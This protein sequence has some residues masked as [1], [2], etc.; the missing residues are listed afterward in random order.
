[1]QKIAERQDYKLPAT[2]DDPAALQEI[3][4]ALDRWFRNPGL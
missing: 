3:D 1:M 2:I 4:D